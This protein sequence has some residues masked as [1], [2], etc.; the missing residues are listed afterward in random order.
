MR[1][2]TIEQLGSNVIS[3]R[4]NSEVDQIRVYSDQELEFPIWSAILSE[5]LLA[6]LSGIMGGA[7][8]VLCS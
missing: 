2:A 6:V 3:G 1:R 7:L 8:V 5:V 4:L